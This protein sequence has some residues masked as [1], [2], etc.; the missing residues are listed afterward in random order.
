M[1][2]RHFG[3]LLLCM[4]GFG[5][6]PGSDLQAADALGTSIEVQTDSARAAASSQQ[7][8]D[9]LSDASRELLEEYRHT[10]RE[11]DSLRAYDDHLER[12][13][14]AQEEDI[15][16]L[17]R[18][19]DEVQ[20][21]HREIIPLLARM[22]DTLERFVE[23]DMPFL[24]EERRARVR[25]L[26]ALL[27]RPDAT[28][29]EKYRRVMEAYQVETDYARTI[30]AYRGP[31]AEGDGERRVDFLRVGRV[32]LLYRSLDGT[33]A[34]AWNAARQSWQ[35]LPPEYLPALKQ[36][37]RIAKKQAAPELLTIPVA[38]PETVQ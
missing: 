33:R 9:N 5:P 37:F 19:L 20:V 14:Q 21:T 28:V 24:P 18:A 1:R 15:A 36:G 8:I 25:E 13:V 35:T 38:A 26:Q 10:L 22:V 4:L 29:A 6:G 34:G 16:G 31:L 23:L 2:Y 30:E 3:T 17:E 32:A 12:M 11:L 7:R 27:D